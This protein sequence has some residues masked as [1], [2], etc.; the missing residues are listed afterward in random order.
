LALF[1]AAAAGGAGPTIDPG[2][3]P[4]EVS[5]ALIKRGESAGR[6]ALVVTVDRLAGR[7]QE[8]LF[9]L[10]RTDAREC[11][12]CHDRSSF[13]AR[14]V[15]W[16][17]YD[18]IDLTN[19]TGSGKSAN[20]S[21]DTVNRMRDVTHMKILLKRIVTPEDAELSVQNGI[22]G[23]LVSNHGGRADD[24]GH[25]TIDALPEIIATVKGQ[26][27]IG[28]RQRSVRRALLTSQGSRSRCCR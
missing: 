11:L 26:Q 10:M 3:P 20:L 16:H 28:E 8:T 7:N 2:L 18:G 19:I 17:N 25:S 4:R 5:Q 1:L 14:M 12:V 13:A 21:W 6:P 22:D 15:R 27:P 9:R 23:I 24:N